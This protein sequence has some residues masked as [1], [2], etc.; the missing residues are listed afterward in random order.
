MCTM[1]WLCCRVLSTLKEQLT[2]KKADLEAKR[3]S[4]IVAEQAADP[5]AAAAAQ[6]EE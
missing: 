5:T 6:P 3:Q 1:P 2:T 4:V